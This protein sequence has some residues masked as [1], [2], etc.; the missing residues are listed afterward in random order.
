M[1]APGP[2]TLR[3]PHCRPQFCPGWR[4]D[5][6][7]LLA[8]GRPRFGPQ[9]PTRSLRA[10]PE[11]FWSTEAGGVIHEHTGRV[12][13]QN[14]T[15]KKLKK[16]S[17]LVKP[18]SSKPGEEAGDLG[19]M[20]GCMVH[21]P[22]APARLEENPESHGHETHTTP[23]TLSSLQCLLLALLTERLSPLLES[24]GSRM[25]CVLVSGIWATSSD[26]W[27]FLVSGRVSPTSVSQET[28]TPAFRG[29]P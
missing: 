14:T 18:V 9:H 2:T 24:Q 8:Q 28:G 3:L 13:P 17:V 21:F 4:S 12:W 10:Q 23:V 26:A 22:K 29:S 7:H 15:N 11:L 1:R 25:S 16:K 19:W 6:T 20:L 5:S 27:G